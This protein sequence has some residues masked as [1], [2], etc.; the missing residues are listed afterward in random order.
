[1]PIS[2]KKVYHKIATAPPP[3]QPEPQVQD[4]QPEPVQPDPQIQS[5]VQ[6]T[7]AYTPA[8]N[9]FNKNYIFIPAKL[10]DVVQLYN[11]SD[12]YNI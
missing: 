11:I 7:A 10:A 2:F 3:P 6:S 1:M 8:V 12:I 5:E 4:P 9:G